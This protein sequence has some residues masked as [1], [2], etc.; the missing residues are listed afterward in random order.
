[1]QDGAAIPIEERDAEEVSYVAGQTDDGRTARVRL[2]PHGTAAKNFGFD[3][4]P[5]RLVT[6]LIT[7]RGVCAASREG[8]LALFS[9]RGPKGAR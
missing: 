6:S 1:M 7:E 2:T 3:V 4:T 9:E 8:L 5:S